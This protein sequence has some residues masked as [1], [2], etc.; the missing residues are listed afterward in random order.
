MVRSLMLEFDPVVRGFPQVASHLQL[1]LESV[2][3]FDIG[4][5]LENLRRSLG[6]LSEVESAIRAEGATLVDDPDF[7]ALT[8]RLREQATI[9]NATIIKREL[10]EGIGSIKA[11][12]EITRL[13]QPV[14][15]IQSAWERDLERMPGR[16]AKDLT[17]EMTVKQCRDGLAAAAAN[18]DLA[19][20][21]EWINW[22]GREERRIAS[23]LKIHPISYHWYEIAEW[24]LWLFLLFSLSWS[25][26]YVIHTSARVDF[27]WIRLGYWISLTLFSFL[28][29]VCVS[30]K[31][32]ASFRRGVR[33][34]MN[35][36]LFMDLNLMVLL[37]LL[38]ICGLGGCFKTLDEK[39]EA[40]NGN[41]DIKALYTMYG[42][43]DTSTGRW[44]YV[45]RN[46][47]LHYFQGHARL[48]HD[49]V[50]KIYE[51]AKDA[52]WAAERKDYK[53]ANDALNA[54]EMSF[55]VNKYWFFGALGLLSLFYVNL[56]VQVLNAYFNTGL[57][58]W[59]S[60][61]REFGPPIRS[62][63]R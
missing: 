38:S 62:C 18:G 42:N 31:A 11:K 20:A 35:H 26:Y 36:D 12:K 1:F 22:F 17:F 14:L 24:A 6:V 5:V 15:E 48:E 57:T 30:K 52:Q 49:A 9:H 8:A 4:S 21:S 29:G 13:R 41:A 3:P 60:I 37:L 46:A 2:E 40:A 63:K 53:T 51:A 44:V 7:Q 47:D 25:V 34:R 23:I 59:V 28:V 45:D 27:G 33:R 55:K 61:L 56:I 10:L 32:R 58:I 54:L 16:L 43:K 39:L 19:K 50:R